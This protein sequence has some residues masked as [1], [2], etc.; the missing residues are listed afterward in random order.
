M[1]PKVIDQILRESKPAAA[2][3]N[4]QEALSSLGASIGKL[5]KLKA[6]DTITFSRF[7]RLENE[8]L[9]KIS[10]LRELQGVYIKALLI[11]EP[12][13][14]GT[15][16]ISNDFDNV[17]SL[18]DN[19]LDTLDEIK[20]RSDIQQALQ[21]LKPDSV[22]QSNDNL[23]DILKGMQIEHNRQIEKKQEEHNKQIE[24]KQE[25]HNKQMENLITNLSKN[26]SDNIST[27][28]KS[29]QDNID[30]LAKS[31]S[32]A[33]PKPSQPHF[34]SK[35]SDTDFEAFRDFLPRFEHFV[36]KVSS[37]KQKLE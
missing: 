37:D 2:Y 20:Q 22:T 32:T 21:D 34:K 27:L 19:C 28:I 29:Q 25:E 7:T 14:H 31:N 24:K 8:L 1:A 9:V 17:E 23:A 30:K 26:S 36:S 5:D 4:R 35:E 6:E 16:D 33:A 10:K 15:E 12:Q 13:L 18:I 3:A 11:S